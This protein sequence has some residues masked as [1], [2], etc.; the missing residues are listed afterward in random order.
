MHVVMYSGLR[1]LIRCPPRLSFLGE[2]SF[3]NRISIPVTLLLIVNTPN[4]SQGGSETTA[5]LTRQ[6][7]RTQSVA[8]VEMKEWRKQFHPNFPYH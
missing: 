4:S 7:R 5:F 8:I 1:L 2:I 3:S 6:S